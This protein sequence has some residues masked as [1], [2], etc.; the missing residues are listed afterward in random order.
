MTYGV[1]DKYN[2]Y[3]ETPFMES[4]NKIY[5]EYK[6]C[7][8]IYDKYPVCTGH[9]LFIPKVNN[10]DDIQEAFKY[11]L[12][13]GETQT[14][15]NIINGYHLGMNLHRAGGQSVDWPHVHFIPRYYQDNGDNEDVGS[16]RLARVGGKRPNSYKDHPKYGCLQ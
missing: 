10:A 6:N 15:K 16:V 14:Q 8:A 13:E 7:I 1:P 3:L 2:S 4:G 11:A 5:K 12:K 9:L